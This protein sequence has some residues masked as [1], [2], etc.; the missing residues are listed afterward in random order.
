MASHS[1]SIVEEDG[2]RCCLGAL[3]LLRRSSCRMLHHW[4][5]DSPPGVRA[6]LTVQPFGETASSQ[7]KSAR[8]LPFQIVTCTSSPLPL[9][10][11][12]HHSLFLRSCPPPAR[13]RVVGT[14][15]KI[16]ACSSSAP[17]A[18]AAAAWS[19]ARLFSLSSSFRGGRS[20]AVS[21]AAPDLWQTKVDQFRQSFAAQ[22]R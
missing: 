13:S 2:V 10:G 18:I 7:K 19:A 6:R 11:H 22:T 1:S 17:S 9:P 14:R 12:H 8:S 5:T 21:A 20:H 3:L 15:G 4:A 16:G